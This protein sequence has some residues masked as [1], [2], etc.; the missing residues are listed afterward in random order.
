[1]EIIRCKKCGIEKEL[2]PE[3]FYFSKKGICKNKSTCRQCRI[4]QHREYNTKNKELKKRMCHRE[5]EPM[6][7]QYDYCMRRKCK[8][9]KRDGQCGLLNANLYHRLKW[10]P[11]ENL[12]EI[13]KKKGI[14][15]W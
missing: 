15:I 10:K 8:T 11:F 5:L 1:M 13:M 6:I 9:C 3:N 2:N 4:L 14:K 12:P 7:N